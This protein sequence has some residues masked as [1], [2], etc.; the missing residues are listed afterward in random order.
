M[1]RLSI[2][3]VSCDNYAD[4]WGPFF[5]L[6]WKY[7]PDCPYPVYLGANQ[8]TCGDPRVK[9]VLTGEDRSWAESTR[10]M[11]EQ[12]PGEYLLMLLE[13]FLLRKPVNTAQVEQCYQA[14]RNLGGGYLRL[15][16]FPKPDRRVPGYPMIGEIEPGAPYR[17]A[18]QAAIWRKEV[19]LSLLQDGETAWDMELIGSRRSDVLREGFYCTWQPVLVYRAGVTMGKWVPFAVRICQEEGVSID[20]SARP[21]MTRRENW[22]RSRRILV[23]TLINCIPWQ[24]RRPLGNLLRRLNLLPPRADI[25]QTS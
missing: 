19:L 12:V 13:D 3:I 6:F 7:W 4:V 2:L 15:K 16:P 5:A 23:G 25:R 17:A 14:L 9:M 21:V 10:H 1:S 18:L 8:R 20:F 22:Q 11:V 24:Y